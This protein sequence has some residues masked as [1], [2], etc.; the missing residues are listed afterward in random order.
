M[1]PELRQATLE[2]C[3]IPPDT[4]PPSPATL[5]TYDDLAAYLQVKVP[6]LYLWVRQ[7][8][9]PSPKRIGGSARYTADQIADIMNGVGEPGKYK[10]VA[11]V[12]SL[13]SKKAMTKRLKAK[14]TGKPPKK[15]PTP[16]K[17]KA[18]A[19]KKK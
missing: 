18:K 15:K 2:G 12:K 7:G 8:R 14:A 1:E 13:A 5:Y 11:S 17:P 3:T 16:K 4:S 9:I 6:T 10:P 19:R